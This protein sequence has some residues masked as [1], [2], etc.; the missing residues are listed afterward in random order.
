M[1]AM[2]R[3]STDLATL[4]GEIEKE[5]QGRVFSEQQATVLATKLETARLNGKCEIYKRRQNVAPLS[6]TRCCKNSDA[7]LQNIFVKS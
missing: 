2:S 3:L 5:R 1:K 4:R 7:L 6:L